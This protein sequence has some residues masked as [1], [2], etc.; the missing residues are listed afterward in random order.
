MASCDGAVSYTHLDVYKRQTFGHLYADYYVFQYATG[1]SGANALA[2]RVLSGG[3][4]AAQDY[5]GFL[6]AGGSKYPLD[7]L[8][9]AGVDLSTPGPVETAFGVL[10][11]LV[12]RLEGLVN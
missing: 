10:A 8:K 4:G 5:L 1:I 9:S 12:E 2:R 11:D 7:A 6:K 3:P